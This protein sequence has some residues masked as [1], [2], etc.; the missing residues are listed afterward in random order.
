MKK[1]ATFI[2]CIISLLLIGVIFYGIHLNQLK[3]EAK[4]EAE[5]KRELE[6]LYYE[7]NTAFWLT[8]DFSKIYSYCSF[9]NANKKNTAISIYAYNAQSDHELT[10]D[11]FYTYISK[12]YDSDGKPMIYSQPEII[13]EYIDWYFNEGKKKID[14]YETSFIVYLVRKGE[15]SILDMN[16]EEIVANLEEF[17]KDPEYNPFIEG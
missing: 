14:R 6:F 17:Q 5:E 7:Q 8:C 10:L 11:E 15:K 13:K 3:E 9:E 16:Y 1:K 12:E 2:I 4:K